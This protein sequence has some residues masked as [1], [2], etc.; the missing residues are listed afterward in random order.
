M[1]LEPS[2]PPLPRYC[3]SRALSIAGR[4][5]GRPAELPQQGIRYSTG[6]AACILGGVNEMVTE[7]V[8]GLKPRAGPG[9]PPCNLVQRHFALIAPFQGPTGGPGSV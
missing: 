8:S 6:D 3:D 1:N 4:A 2:A 5:R 7:Q 9:M